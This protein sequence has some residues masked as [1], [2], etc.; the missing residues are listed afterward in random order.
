MRSQKSKPSFFKLLSLTLA[1]SQLALLPQLVLAQTPSSTA[2][3]DAV[4]NSQLPAENS[5]LEEEVNTITANTISQTG[6][7]IPSLWWAKEQFDIYG[8]KLITNWFAYPE[9]QQI[10]LVVN[11]QLWTL[12]NYLGR[13]RLVN[14]FGTVAREY[15]YTLRIFNQYQKCLAT[16]QYNINSVPPKWEIKF[17][18]SVQ[19]GLQINTQSTF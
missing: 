19:D 17:D 18:P 1:T 13:Y 11:R 10:D 16:Y 9:K 7:T 3:C 8:G 12:L 6:I 2:T 4:A 5:Q 14:E 15:G